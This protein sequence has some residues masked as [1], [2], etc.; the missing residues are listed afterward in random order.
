MAGFIVVLQP[1]LLL[2]RLDFF[3]SNTVSA[4]ADWFGL[5]LLFATFPPAVGCCCSR[6]GLLAGNDAGTVVAA[7][8][9]IWS[10]SFSSLLLPLA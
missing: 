2:I 8:T 4:E 5:V 10:T 7:C 3:I 1:L 9:G 6:K